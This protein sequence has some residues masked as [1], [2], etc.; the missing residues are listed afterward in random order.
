M[1]PENKKPAYYTANAY[2]KV[3]L[4]LMRAKK[5]EKEIKSRAFK[6]KETFYNLWRIINQ[7]H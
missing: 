1:N 2:K 5:R 4:N 6:V 3:H 7:L